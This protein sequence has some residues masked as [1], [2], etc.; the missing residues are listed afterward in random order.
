RAAIEKAL[1]IRPN[2]AE[3]LNSLGTVYAKLSDRTRAVAMFERA[4]T[5]RPNYVVARFNLAEAYEQVNPRRA[6]AEYETY[7][8]LV[9]DIAEEKGRAALAQQRVELLKR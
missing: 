4:V 2:T 9:E 5:L 8:A 6:I 1:A 3:F 7:L